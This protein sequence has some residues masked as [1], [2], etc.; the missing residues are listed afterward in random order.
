MDW[1]S[2]Y[3]PEA[4][5]D[6]WNALLE[7]ARPGARVIFRSAGLKV[8]YLDHLRVQHRGQEADLG[9][10]LR[11]NAELAARLHERDRVHTYGNFFIVDLPK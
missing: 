6:E 4:L 1:M 9:S 7:K 2:W 5:V 10:L 11:H 3:F 8:T